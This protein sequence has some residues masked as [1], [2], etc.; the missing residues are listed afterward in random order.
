VRTTSV[1]HQTK[2]LDKLIKQRKSVLAKLES[3]Y[4]KKAKDKNMPRR[5]PTIRPRFCGLFGQ[6]V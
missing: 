5:D 2:E 4:M 1:N 6:K 3:A